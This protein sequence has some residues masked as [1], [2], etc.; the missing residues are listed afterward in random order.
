[1]HRVFSENGSESELPFH[2][3]NQKNVCELFILQMN[4]HAPLPREI[5]AL[6]MQSLPNVLYRAMKLCDYELT[7][8]IDLLRLF[9]ITLGQHFVVIHSYIY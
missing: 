5:D 4:D 2:R 1:M 9:L 7:R 3:G 8:F 6:I